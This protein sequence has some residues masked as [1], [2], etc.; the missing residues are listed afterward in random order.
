MY[1]YK[2]NDIIGDDVKE[3]FFQAFK[4]ITG[5]D[6]DTVPAGKRRSADIVIPRTSK[7][8]IDVKA[9]TKKAMKKL[10]DQIKKKIARANK[11]Y[12]VNSIIRNAMSQVIAAK[13]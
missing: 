8:P 4:K 11:G 13:A 7:K 6:I 1:N 10:E 3:E 5:M 12:S 2:K 9:G